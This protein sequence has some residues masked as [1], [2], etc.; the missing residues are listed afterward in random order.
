MS[1]IKSIKGLVTFV[2]GGAEGLGFAT[3]SR[4][5]RNGAK[6]VFCDVP[7]SDG[8]SVVDRLQDAGNP[9]VFVPADVTSESDVRKAIGVVEE[10]FGKLDAVVNCAGKSVAF[11]TYNF[12]KDTAHQLADF[13]NI[14]E[15]NAAGTFNV[16]RWAVEL[17]NRNEPDADGHRGTIV[18]TSGFPAYD[19]Q[20]G[21]VTISSGCGAISAMTLPMARDLASVGIR[22]CTISPGLFNTLLL[23]CIPEHVVEDLVNATPFPTRF[24]K[25][26]EFAHAA[27]FLVENPMMNGHVLNVTGGLRLDL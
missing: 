14:N 20:I 26:D 7:E 5:V 18:N 19:G 4:F 23:T 12:I 8:Q 25:P 2:T 6:V 17:M 22:C 27:Q 3:V 15:T 16:N 13:H 24:G 11:L 9:P 10:K 21:Q 1:R